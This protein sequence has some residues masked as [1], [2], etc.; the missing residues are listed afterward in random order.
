MIPEGG[1]IL[2]TPTEEVQQPSLTYKLDLVNG[3]ISGMVDGLEAIKQAVFLI[4]Q[5]ERF[6]HLIYSFNYGHELKTLIGGNP[7]FV[8]SETSRLLWDALQQD[9]RIR[10]IENVSSTLDGDALTISFTV[11]SVEGTFDV[12]EEVNTG[13]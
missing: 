6:R 4:L 12:T 8:Q 5:S 3:R 11:V 7:L 2:E 13:V 9:D 1:M 10:R